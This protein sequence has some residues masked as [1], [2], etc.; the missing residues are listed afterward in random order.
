MASEGASSTSKLP[1]HSPAEREGYTELTLSPGGLPCRW[2]GSIP[3]FFWKRKICRRPLRINHRVPIPPPPTVG[4]LVSSN[5]HCFQWRPSCWKGGTSWSNGRHFVQTPCY[6]GCHLG[7]IMYIVVNGTLLFPI[8]DI[9]FEG[10]SSCSNGGHLV[11][12]HM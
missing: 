5:G 3:D 2:A 8:A 9:L 6:K 7:P 4:H 11:Q 1:C 12:D 10:R